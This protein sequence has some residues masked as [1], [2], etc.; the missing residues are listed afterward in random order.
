MNFRV[1]ETVLILK[2]DTE[3]GFTLLSSW[4]KGRLISGAFC[5]DPALDPDLSV[6]QSH[7]GQWELDVTCFSE[8]RSC[9]SLPV[10]YVLQAANPRSHTC[11]TDCPEITIFP[12]ARILNAYKTFP[13]IRLCGTCQATMRRPFIPTCWDCNHGRAIDK[14]RREDSCLTAA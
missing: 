9:E 4:L 10:V 3:G 5:S 14:Y 7:K 13:I 1:L 11:L 8:W 6:C 12:R 2:E